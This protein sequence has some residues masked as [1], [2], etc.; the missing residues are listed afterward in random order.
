MFQND[1]TFPAGLLDFFKSPG[2]QGLLGAVAGYATN[3]QR[4]T[5]VNNLGRAAGAGLLAYGGAQDREIKQLEEG[6]QRQLRGMQL[7]KAKAEMAD[8]QWM[9]DNAP[10]FYTPGLP[11]VSGA[12]NLLPPELQTGLLPMPA[13]PAK[14]DSQGFAQAR[15]AQN[16]V[17]GLEMLTALQKDT[18]FGKVDAKDYTPESVKKFTQTR[19]FGDLVARS[20]MEVSPGGQVFDPYGIKPGQFMA[21][22]NKPMMMTAGGPVANVP[23]QSYE[24]GKAKAG[25]SNTSIKV[26]NKMGEGLASQVG[27]MMK[28]SVSSAEGAAKQIDAANRIISAVDSNKMF[29]GTGAE[30]RLTV[31]QAADSLGVGGNTNTE[32]IA[33]TR[34]ALQGLSQLTLQGRAQ[35]KGQGAITES[36]SKLAERATSGDISMTPGEIKQLANAAKRAANYMQAEHGRKVD[37]I[38][39]NPSLAG[40]APFY[41]VNS[42][43]AQTPPPATT[44][45]AAVNPAMRWNPTTRKLDKVQ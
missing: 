38:K 20:K 29:A 45:T 7:G 32:K 44:P 25:A 24:M 31:A 1:S 13:Q 35:M 23:F 21:D 22:P 34:Q 11:A 41:D 14:F 15:M 27:P 18:P 17:K 6:Q 33:N 26:E 19:S 9:R 3:A 36:E 43:P 12:D 16:P 8:D 2:G 40:M 28:D 4:G 30:L 5:P 10:K 42:V 37:V 39:N